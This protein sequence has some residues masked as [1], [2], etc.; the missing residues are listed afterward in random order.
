MLKWIQNRFFIRKNSELRS[1][2][3]PNKTFFSYGSLAFLRFCMRES[4][5]GL[6]LDCLQWEWQRRI[7]SEKLWIFDPVQT[8]AL[9][10]KP[11]NL[12]SNTSQIDFKWTIIVILNWMS[13]NNFQTNNLS[14]F[15]NLGQVWRKTKFNVWS[16]K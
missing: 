12:L 10:E 11:F 14:S 5:S 9:I 6:L 2:I 4:F 8:T 16:W 1:H 3:D 13:I 15:I 7:F